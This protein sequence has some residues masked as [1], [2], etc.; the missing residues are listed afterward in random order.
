MI[1][2]PELTKPDTELSD[3]DAQ[4]VSGVSQFVPILV[5]WAILGTF[6][7]VV[8]VL[9][10]A[11]PSTGW[12]MEPDEGDLRPSSIFTRGMWQS[13]LLKLSGHAGG[14]GFLELDTSAES[15]DGAPISTPGNTVWRSTLNEYRLAAIFIGARHFA[16]LLRRDLSTGERRA[17]DVTLGDVIDG[18]VLTYIG[19]RSI[20]LRSDI[21]G[22]QIELILFE[23]SPK[24]AVRQP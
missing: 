10:D 4:T 15:V 20:L 7:F 14:E 13:Y 9:P 22:R 8:R 18:H 2:E 16:V 5:F 1:R 17:L 23:P 11:E 19:A 3:T 12:V 6:D 24:N 21:K